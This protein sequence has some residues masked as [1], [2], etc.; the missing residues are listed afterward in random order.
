[1]AYEGYVV[2]L[3]N[4]LREANCTVSGASLSTQAA[5]NLLTPR[6]SEFWRLPTLDPAQAELQFHFSR[7]E[8]LDVAG[9]VAA[10]FTPG[11]TYRMV[12][13][14]ATIDSSESIAPDSL[15]AS[16][17]FTGGLANVDEDPFSPDGLA[18]TQTSALSAATARFTFASPVGAA[19][20]AGANYQAFYVRVTAGNGAPTLKAELYES[21]SL[22]ANLGTQTIATLS[23][24]TVRV[25]GFYW[26][27]ALLST[28]SG[29]NVEVLLT[30][31]AAAS[32]S[33]IEGL[34]WVKDSWPDP[35]TGADTGYQTIPAWNTD[36]S[37]GVDVT[38]LDLGPPPQRTLR[39]IWS[40]LQA[41]MYYLRV[42]IRDLDNPAGYL[43]AGVAIAGRKFA[44]A[45]SPVDFGGDLLNTIDPSIKQRTPGGQIL[46][47]NRV[48]WDEV[49]LR[50]HNTT[51]EAFSVR[52]RWTQ[53]R[54]TT[55]PVLFLAN[56]N[57]TAYEQQYGDKYGVLKAQTS[58]K[59]MRTAVPHWEQSFTL[60]EAL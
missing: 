35:G 15:A 11:A 29:A 24:G 23:P 39:Y 40:S 54:G 57:G 21:G 45:L 25:L 60:E 49:S 8:S 46:S 16:S 36:P 42:Q 5:S 4:L 30:L 37:T 12:L 14:N 22:K 32:A 50:F 20:A 48:K 34:K 7:S 41:G 28:S 59:P 33:T 44:A 47:T 10:N 3:P 6:P 38:T 18:M 55:Q 1:M 9:F 26:N 19:P 52:D 51:A 31:S 2:G 27:A 13:S 58:M 17:N 53:R 43:Q 56:P